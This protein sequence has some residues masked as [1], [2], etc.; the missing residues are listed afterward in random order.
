[1]DETR[2]ASQGPDELCDSQG[3]SSKVGMYQSHQAVQVIRW[4]EGFE[5]GITP[6]A[7]SHTANSHYHVRC[8]E[9]AQSAECL[10]L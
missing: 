10:S 3:L 2:Y 8:F 1:M 7:R 4:H 5:A 6:R 9:S